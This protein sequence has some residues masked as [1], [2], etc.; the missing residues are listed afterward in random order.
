MPT[1]NSKDST[2]IAFDKTG[3]GPALILVGGMFEQR[4]MESETSDGSPRTEQ[5]MPRIYQSVSSSASL[6]ETRPERS[7]GSVILQLWRRWTRVC[8]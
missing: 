3:S 8:H 4:A 5:I 1:V 7:S 6:A 2:T